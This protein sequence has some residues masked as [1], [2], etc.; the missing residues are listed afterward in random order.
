[1]KN[2]YTLITCKLAILLEMHSF[3]MLQSKRE[4]AVNIPTLKSA[5]VKDTTNT[6]VLVRSWR[7]PYARKMTNPFT[8]TVR[9]QRNQPKIQNHWLPSTLKSNKDD[10]YCL[11]KSHS[12]LQT[13]MILEHSVRRLLHRVWRLSLVFKKNGLVIRN[14]KQKRN[15]FYFII[16]CV[17]FVKTTA[18]CR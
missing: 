4:G 15:I 1:M 3:T 9:M 6:L 11:A 13:F 14:W 8:T 5:T 7:L 18:E 12:R 17:S 2:T 16:W 10:G